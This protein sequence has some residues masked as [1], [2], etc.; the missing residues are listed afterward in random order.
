MRGADRDGVQEGDAVQGVK[1]HMDGG[2][3][4]PIPVAYDCRY[5]Q[6]GGEREEKGLCA[7]IRAA[8]LFLRLAAHLSQPVPIEQ[9]FIALDREIGVML[10][11]S[12]GRD[13]VRLVVNRNYKSAIFAHLTVRDLLDYYRSD[14]GSEIGV[15][16]LIGP[17]GKKIL[18]ADRV[19]GV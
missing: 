11:E 9:F 15:H 2:I 8:D 4:D 13:I 7:K 5:R 10:A 12:T 17:E 19:A 6:K 3:F 16:V 18:P 1:F 14:E